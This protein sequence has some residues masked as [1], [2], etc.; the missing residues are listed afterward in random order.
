ML[1]KTKSNNFWIRF[2]AVK[3]HLIWTYWLKIYEWPG[4]YLNNQCE[5]AWRKIWQKNSKN[6]IK[7]LLKKTKSN[8]FWIRFFAVK[9][10][11]IWTYWLKI[12]E[13]SGTYLNNHCENAWRK[14]WQKNSK[15]FIKK[16]LKK[17]K[18]NNFW[19][20]FFAVKR[21]LIWTYWLKIYEWSGTYLNNHCENAW[22]KIWQKNSKNFIKNC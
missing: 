9:R 22:R 21:H 15:N 2:F 19:I 13:W 18:S 17:T 6:F 5:N 7:K 14:I 20:R 4:T 3:R 1:Q 16:L 11:L 8:N 12:Y 10:H